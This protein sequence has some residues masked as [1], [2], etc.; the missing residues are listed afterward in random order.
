MM[1]TTRKK[2]RLV[3]GCPLRNQNLLPF[4]IIFCKSSE[5]SNV[6]YNVA[7]CHNYST[8]F[9][10]NLMYKGTCFNS[11]C[12]LNDKRI[13]LCLLSYF[14]QVDLAAGMYY[15]L[16]KDW[17]D[18]FGWDQ[19]KIVRLEDYTKDS[20]NV[21]NDI[22][23]FLGLRKYGHESFTFKRSSR[24]Y[25]TTSQYIHVCKQSSRTIQAVHEIELKSLTFLKIPK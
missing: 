1:Y 21:T 20:V 13:L 9:K 25:L 19:L 12:I 11:S 4:N 22:F 24:K 15:P 18:V 14:F 10:N 17:Y 2:F 5:E 16:F 7:L 8:S 3:C 23:K 6:A